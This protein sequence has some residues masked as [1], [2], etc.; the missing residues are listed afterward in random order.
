MRDIKTYG[1]QIQNQCELVADKCY[2]REDVTDE[3]IGLVLKQ[4]VLYTELI[5]QS[6]DNFNDFNSQISN[7]QESF[8]NLVKSVEDK[9]KILLADYLHFEISKEID[10][11]ISSMK[12]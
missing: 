9:D 12:K 11:W 6:S 1:R 5:A 8:S 4:I 2:Q 10:G 7:W 3:M